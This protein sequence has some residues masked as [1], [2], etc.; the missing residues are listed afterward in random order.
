M[1]VVRGQL[2]DH[3]D[4]SFDRGLPHQPLTETQAARGLL[5]VIRIGKRRRQHQ[6]IVAGVEE[7]RAGHGT[8]P[9]RQ[10]GERQ[11]GGVLGLEIPAQFFG[12]LELTRLDPVGR[13]TLDAELQQRGRHV[14]GLVRQRAELI[15]RGGDDRLVELALSEALEAARDARQGPQRAAPEPRRQPDDERQRDEADAEPVTGRLRGRPVQAV[16][17]GAQGLPVEPRRTLDRVE[18]PLVLLLHPRHVTDQLFAGLTV[19]Q[20]QGHVDGGALVDDERLLHSLRVCRIDGA[21][22]LR[23][24]GVHARH[25]HA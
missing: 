2:V 15:C 22:P 17:A 1:Q 24:R 11:L 3:A 18:R 23:D 4:V 10:A 7:Q 8:H 6:L 13:V 25:V 20:P 5:G 19:E 21:P 14:V 9:L 16:E 12:E